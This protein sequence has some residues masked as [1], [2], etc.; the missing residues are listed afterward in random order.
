MPKINS[1][2]EGGYYA[3]IMRS[4][5]AGAPDYHLVLLPVTGVGLPWVNAVE[6][7]RAAGG[8]LPSREEWHLLLANLRGRFSGHGYWAADENGPD[9]AWAI[10]TAD[11]E[12]YTDHRDQA[13]RAVA[14][15]RIPLE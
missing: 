11:G 2:F 8:Q 13:A 9:H 3:G 4:T 5:V 6:F 1:T 7:A 14:I 12:E 15:K 10:W